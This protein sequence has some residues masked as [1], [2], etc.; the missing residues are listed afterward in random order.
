MNAS[1][2]LRHGVSAPLS[3]ELSRE[4]R[5]DQLGV[6]KGDTVTV[7]RGN[8]RGV[9]GKVT[10][11][12]VKSGKVYVEGV[13]RERADGTAKPIAIDASKVILRQVVLDDKR[14]KD[15]IERRVSVNAEI[16]EKPKKERRRRLSETKAKKTEAKK[17]V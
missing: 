8:F 15:I 1:T 16:E 3:K 17:E 10:R 5:V 2:I 12:D 14:R 11:V 4:H 6:R 13:S 9:E 7:T